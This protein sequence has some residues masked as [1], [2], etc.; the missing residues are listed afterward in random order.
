MEFL[1]N[2]YKNIEKFNL[3]IEQDMILHDG[4]LKGVLYCRGEN[5]SKIILIK[6]NKEEKY[7]YLYFEIYKD[8]LIFFREKLNKKKEILNNL[9]Q[10][11]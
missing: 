3:I 6:I 8:W 9:V 11:L 2:V 7:L 5:L 1:L 4:V 10:N